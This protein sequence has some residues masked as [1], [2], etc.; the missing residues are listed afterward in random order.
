MASRG[1]IVSRLDA[2]R[3]EQ[4]PQALARLA[5]VGLFV[6]LWFMLWI[7]RIPMPVPFLCTLVAEILFFV[8]YWRSVFLLR[9]VRAI[10]LAHYVMLAAE[11]VFH[12]T[13]VYFLGGVTWLGAFAYVF[14]LIFTNTFLD[15]RRG[16]LYTAG[17]SCAF[18][19]LILLQATGTIPHYV[20]L[21]QGPLRYTDPA[22]VATT[23]VGGAGVFFSIYLWVNWVGHQLRVERDTAV[24]A[25]D[26]LLQ[27]RADLQRANEALEERVQARTAAL[28]ESQQQLNLVLETCP[29][30]I[31][32]QETNAQYRFINNAFK[33]VLGY[34]PEDLV[35]QS[36]GELIHPDDI[37]EVGARF[38]DM[39]QSRRPGEATF[40]FRHKDGHWV[41]LEA[42]GQ[43]LVHESGEATGVV[44]AYRDVT[45]R[46]R[47]EEALRESE[48]RLRILIEGVNAI[49]WA[50]D[51]T[52]WQFSF[53]SR[54]A[55]Q[56]VGYPVRRWLTEPDFWTSHIHPDDRESAVSLCMEAT[57]EGK[58]HDLEYRMIAE[59]GRSVWL[60][61]FVRVITDAEGRP[62]ELRGIMVDV[63]ERKRAEEA[64]RESE[65]RLRA[66]IEST[67]DGILVVD[68]DGGVTHT[69][70][71]FL[72]MWRI[73][74][75]LSET[76]DDDRLLAFV[77]DQL[78][79]PQAFVAKVRELYQSAD[80]SFDTL[81][82]HD[83]RVFERFSRPL[84]TNGVTG[85]VWSF[86][87]ITERKQAEEALR[88][89]EERFRRLAE[90]AVD[91]IFRYRVVPVP[92][93]EYVSPA[94][95]TVLGYTPEQVYADAELAPTLVHPED[96]PGLGRLAVANATD[97]LTLRLFHRNGSL[98]WIEF[99]TVPV[100]N[101]AGELIAIE[102][103]ARDATER[104]RQEEALDALRRHNELIL[105]SAGE[106]IFGLDLEGR[107]TF[108]NPTA[109]SLLGWPAEELI[110]QRQ[111]EIIHH[112]HQDRTPYPA[113]ECPIYAALKDGLVHHMAE[114]VFWRCDGTSFP[115]DYL[116]TP[117]RD[118]RGNLVGAVVTFRDITERKR[119]DEALRE[120]ESKFR[121]MAETVAAATFI[122]QGDKMRYVNP[123]V[124]AI[125]GYSRS[126]L[127]R[128][129]FWDIIHPEYRELVKERGL[130]R[131][132]GDEAPQRYEVKLLTKDGQERWVDFT[133]GTIEFEGKRAVLG[134]AFD[135]TERKWAENALREQTR[136]DP[137]TGLLNHAAIVEELRDVVTQGAADVAHAVAM[138]DVDGLKAV[139]DTYGHQMG[140]LVLLAVG[141][142]LAQDGAAVGRYG[143]DEFVALLRN[144]DR[145][146][147]EQYREAVIA[148]LAEAA[149]TDAETGAAVPMA[150]SIGL[151]I[152]PDEAETIEELIRL[153]DSAMYAWRRQRAIL[154]GEPR[155]AGPLAGDRAAEM[156]GELVPLLTSPSQL[157]DKLRLVA[158]Q[159]SVGAGYDGV[160]FSLF[161]DEPG[162]ELAGSTFARVPEE[163][164]DAWTDN[165]GPGGDERHPIRVLFERVPLPVIIDD[166][167][168]DELLWQSQRD[169]LRAAELRSVL[170]APM[171]WEDRAIGTL[172]VASKR[173]HAFTSR[174]AQF[175]AAVATQV[176][177]VVH[178]ATLVEQLQVSTTRLADAHTDTVMLLASVAEAHDQTT[179]RHLQNVRA[180]VE[181]LA[182]ELGH[183]DEHA[184]D[185]GLAAALHDIGKV[186]VPDEFL[187]HS[188]PL[189]D[190][191]WELMKQHTTWGAELLA[192]RPAFEL[193]ATIARCHH[194]R[195]DGDG[196]PAGLAGPDLPEAAAIVAVADAFDAMVSGRPYREPK[197]V[198]FA[199]REIVRCSGK[200]FSPRVVDALQRLDK[201][202]R[203][204]ISAAHRHAA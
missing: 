105:N 10:E 118:E 134:T 52:T 168:N 141:K 32:I 28:R 133:A 110:G 16:L 139:N 127:L 155:P 40:R 59:D 75:E 58:D 117:I 164:V 107:A 156:I 81:R 140:D 67:G 92:G 27:V 200:Q 124:E 79:E 136:R 62:Q 56:I 45:E 88:E 190:E 85:R 106:G 36:A 158:H 48:E 20:F 29:D 23:L 121:T 195:W 21:E 147:A 187:A 38:R 142:A 130:A 165:Q 146:A 201:Q 178:M 50:A 193:A 2:K 55:E 111:H 12:T 90:N 49:V 137:L 119:Q 177:A 77:L 123:A 70:A 204:P 71:R 13:I 24:R 63:T 53:V 154:P 135:I 86:R 163:L 33:A 153:S 112:S 15:L 87:D 115:V 17:A 25:Q 22:F 103:V 54:Q 109:V 152:Y 144:T 179:G 73:P 162:E 64:L 93:F 171:M 97:P 129:N 7:A 6:G 83:G 101:D 72:E 151:A 159:L 116:S 9:S 192:G 65:E 182:R 189:T 197:S 60:R 203:L 26:E 14:G 132:R 169:L 160:N 172:G 145:A 19:A 35:G 113:G 194:E 98:V 199:L 61:D 174:D 114:E 42:N 31:S 104:R 181:A 186:R 157:S 125:T 100:Y 44:A 43:V 47:A 3:R 41:I 89:S 82:F 108:V 37:E 95:S 149:L 30:L 143:G 196:Y 4:T 126:E 11:I 80:E 167:W 78:V 183:S 91:I 8:L 191:Q 99:R 170:V 175:L 57:A 148:A 120:S 69:N 166:P 184:R 18:G 122:Y 39:V 185:L 102:G 173:E 51:A 96:R 128:Q 66:T 34:E 131:Q 94:I 5:V 150:A 198:A 76:R 176:S 138:V 202:R 74:A 161:S 84:V 46:K 180:L 68:H 188:G 1:D